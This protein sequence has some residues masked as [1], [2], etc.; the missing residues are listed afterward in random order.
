MNLPFKVPFGKKEINQYFL[1]L[2][3]REEKVTAVIFEEAEGKIKPLAKHEESFKESVE[4]ASE[5][6]FLDTLDKAISI[7]E[8]NLP[9]SIETQKTIFGLKETWVEDAKIKRDYLSK[10]KK[11]CDALGL[12][13]VGFLVIHE[14][15]AHLLQKEE[16]APVSAVL[17]EI[18]K[19]HE[20]IT[21]LR[22]GRIIETHRAKIEDSV[23]KTTD[24]LLHHFVNYEVL[25]ARIVL[26]DGEKSDEL[27]QEFISHSWSKDLPFL[28]VPQITVLSEGFDAR[29]V[30]FGAAS[31]M[32]FEV[33]GEGVSAPKR[34]TPNLEEQPQETEKMVEE[35]EI[36]DEK[37]EDFGFVVGK[38]VRQFKKPT[39]VAPE[40]ENEELEEEVVETPKDQPYPTS[41]KKAIA[42]GSLFS[43]VLSNAPRLKLFTKKIKLPKIP[44]S[45]PSFKNTSRP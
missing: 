36:S 7:A 19:K 33:L 18:G 37:E 28:H 23:A 26:F 29:S 35:E 41:L 39:V 4:A 22:G 17:A 42:V 27:S 3:L 32:G 44:F 13:P 5:D 20:V 11:A 2:L 1:A 9:K 34:V 25:P 8:Q 24:R 16:G 30:L 21:L 40:A 6:E 15:I 38:D 10:L 43:M 31:Q 45:L 14:A 12:S